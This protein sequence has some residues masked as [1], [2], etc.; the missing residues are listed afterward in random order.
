MNR[1]KNLFHFIIATFY[2]PVLALSFL[3]LAAPYISTSV[4][5]WIQLIP[6]LFPILA[7]FHLLAV[8]LFVKKFKLLSLLAFLALLGSS[9]VISKDLKMGPS[10]DLAPDANQS[11]KVLSYNVGTFDF[12]AENIDTS[13]ELLKSLEPDVITL[14]EFRNHKLADGSY[15][16][17]YMSRALGM[18][19]HRFVHLPVHIHGAVIY[20]KYPIVDIDTL[21]M[22]RKEIN[23]GILTS[24]ETPVG[25]V[26]VGNVHL[27]SF[28]I[29]QTYNETDGFFDKLIAIFRRAR[30]V[31]KLQNDKVDQI[32]S[33][34]AKYPNPIIITGDMNATPHTRVNSLLSQKMNDSFR[35]GGSGIGWSYPLLNKML[36]LRID[37]QYASSEFEVLEHKIVREGV[38]DHYPVIV[39]Y[40]IQP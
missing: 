25:M 35:E 1:N 8:L 20:S 9:W 19:Y 36:G 39:T 15:A 38:S 27:S 3:G 17:D 26:G 16:I 23:S 22:P 7:L 14:Q 21:F 4:F 33:K 37:H 5:S 6:N 11:L 28:Q 24:I 12:K 32:L 34:T 40:R 30:M 29:A 31:V 10:E 18:P 2:A 13:S